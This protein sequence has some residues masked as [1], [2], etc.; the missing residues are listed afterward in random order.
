MKGRLISYYTK[1]I[2][3]TILGFPRSLK[4]LAKSR[5]ILLIIYLLI[6]SKLSKI[7]RPFTKCS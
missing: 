5:T 2:R 3:T 1:L 4:L 7:N 6:I